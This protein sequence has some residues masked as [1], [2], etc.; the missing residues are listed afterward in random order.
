MRNRALIMLTLACAALLPADAFAQGLFESLFGGLRRAARQVPQAVESYSRSYSNE[1][2]FFPSG[3]QDGTIR[4]ETGPHSAYCVRTCDGHY[5][6]VNAQRG[7]SVA[8][9]CQSMCP[10]AETK[11]YSGGGIDYAADGRGARY[12]DMPTAFLYRK[13]LVAN[14]TCN[15]KTAGGLAT[16][17]AKDDP[18]LRP[19]DIVAGKSGLMAFTGARDKTAQFTPARDFR[20][21]GTS[22]R[23]RLS[24][25][26]VSPHGRAAETTGAPAND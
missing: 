24:D 1:G 20:G 21:F 14:C 13:Q 25:M 6:P 4:G 15:G 10:Y 23:D 5:F 11:I 19:G 8:E 26:K 7:M 2:G 9:A 16:L 12:A 17:D 3:G 18:T 22:T